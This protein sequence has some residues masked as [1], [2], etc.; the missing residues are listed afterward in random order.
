MWIVYRDSY[1]FDTVTY[2]SGIQ[3]SKLKLILVEMFVVSVNKP[4][5]NVVKQGMLGSEL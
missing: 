3:T 5:N 2:D 1:I 4:T